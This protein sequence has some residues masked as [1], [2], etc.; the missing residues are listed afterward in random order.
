MQHRLKWSL[1]RQRDGRDLLRQRE[2]RRTS[3]FTGLIN[4]AQWSIPFGLATLQPR[5]KSEYRHERPYST[6]RPVFST[7]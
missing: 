5:F 1:Y 6:R 2:G 4:R 7:V 3:D